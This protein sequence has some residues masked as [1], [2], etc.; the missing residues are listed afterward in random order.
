[1]QHFPTVTQPVRAVV[2]LEASKSESR[3]IG[4]HC[5]MRSCLLGKGLPPRNSGVLLN[6]HEERMTNSFWDGHL[7]KMRVFQAARGRDGQTTTGVSLIAINT[8]SAHLP[9]LRN[10]LLICF[11][12]W[13][14][15]N[16]S[17]E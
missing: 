3:A 17:F 16:I 11:T 13:I 1:M 14:P 4:L 12:P 7:G 15:H 10:I 6:G 5:Y 9:H 2:N 8:L